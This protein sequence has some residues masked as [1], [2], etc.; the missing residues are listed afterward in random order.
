MGGLEG[1]N[2]LEKRK[3]QFTFAMSPWM[4]WILLEAG[5]KLE[6]EEDDL[7]SYQNY[8]GTFAAVLHRL[9][10][11]GKLAWSFTVEE[12]GPTLTFKAKDLLKE[13]S[14]LLE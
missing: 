1:K 12:D 10:E 13:L 3:V 9:L 11:K 14:E 8:V 5:F 4:E 7:T 2:L 6:T